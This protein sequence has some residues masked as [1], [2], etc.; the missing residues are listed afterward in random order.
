MSGE[1][2]R[3]S[4]S[5]GNSLILRTDLVA[6]EAD[7]SPLEIERAMASGHLEFFEP[8]DGLAG[9]EVGGVTIAKGRIVLRGGRHYLKVLRTSGEAGQEAQP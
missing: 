1:Y 7:L 5:Y 2:A 4:G 6:A 8:H 3:I 9:L